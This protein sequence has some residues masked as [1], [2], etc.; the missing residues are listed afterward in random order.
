MVSAGLAAEDATRGVV[1]D[2]VRRG[3]GVRALSTQPY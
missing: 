3:D 2:V 1:Q